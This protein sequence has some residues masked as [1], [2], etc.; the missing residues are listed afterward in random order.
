MSAALVGV[1]FLLLAI[2]CFAAAATGFLA[3]L[4]P[5]PIAWGLLFLTLYIAVVGWKPIV[6]A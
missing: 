1:I 6:R 5:N 2:V 3:A 4:I